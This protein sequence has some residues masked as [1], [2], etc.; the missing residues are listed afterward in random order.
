MRKIKFQNDYYYHI[1]NRGVDKRE[2]FLDKKDYL[3]FLESINNFNTPTFNLQKQLN[4][5]FCLLYFKVLSCS[6]QVQ[7]FLSEFC[8]SGIFWDGY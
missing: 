7:T 8:N 3:R 4:E 1:C 2:V 6:F 5:K